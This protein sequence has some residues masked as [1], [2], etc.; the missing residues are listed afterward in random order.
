VFDASSTRYCDKCNI[1]VK[2][3]TGGDY[4]WNQHLASSDHIRNSKAAPSKKLTAF[5]T[6][7]PKVSFRRSPEAGPSSAAGNSLILPNTLPGYPDT[8]LLDTGYETTAIDTVFGQ[9]HCGEN[10]DATTQTD[11]GTISAITPPALNSVESQTAP[12]TIMIAQL[13]A[14]AS[15]LPDSVPLGIDTDDLAR[16]SGDPEEE[17]RYY[18]DPW[19]MVDQALNAVIGYNMGA[20][21]IAGLI[22]RGKHG[23]DGLCNWLE[24]CINTLRIDAVLLDGKVKRLLD[25]M[26]LL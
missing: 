13:R 3:G 2:I 18:E 12:G 16:F 4:N 21:Q 14:A 17:S 8:A 26:A 6:R 10:L 20:A 24:A 25:A 23:I 19:E 5:F 1:E 9:T 15:R 7:A 22:R 11:G